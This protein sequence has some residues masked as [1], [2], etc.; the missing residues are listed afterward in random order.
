MNSLV[1]RLAWVLNGLGTRAQY[2]ATR[3]NTHLDNRR[4][5]GAANRELDSP[6]YTEDVEVLTFIKYRRQILEPPPVRNS[7]SFGLYERQLRTL[8]AV[9][10]DNPGIRRALN[11]GVSYGYVNAQVAARFPE[12]IIEGIDRSP[13]TKAMNEVEFPAPNLKFIAADIFDHLASATYQDC[14][15]FHSRTLTYLPR[16]WVE[17]FYRAVAAAG[18][19]TVVVHE[20]FGRSRETGR[21]YTFDQVPRP[22]VLF[23]NRMFTH[24]YPALLVA[25]GFKTVAWSE[26]KTDHLD[27]DYRMLEVV[28]HR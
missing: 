23:R 20:Q 24:N 4:M 14:L 28:A 27:P 8:A 11:F 25:A 19:N 13:F 10:K 21:V 7:E 6:G 16:P 12:V 17:R 5:V 3:L 26:F 15:L 1:A 9:L 18:F 2:W 22:S